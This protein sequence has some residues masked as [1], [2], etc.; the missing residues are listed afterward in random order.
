MI[1]L[2]NAFQKNSELKTI[3]VKIIDKLILQNLI[4]VDIVAEDSIILARLNSRTIRGTSALN[5]L[6][7]SN[8]E[9]GNI[10]TISARSLIRE[11][12]QDTKKI[13]VFSIQN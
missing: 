6:S 12:A 7:S 13:K 1:I 5:N 2:K 8:L 4:I 11:M 10:A 3:I 9:R